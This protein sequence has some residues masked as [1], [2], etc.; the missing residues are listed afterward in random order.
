MTVDPNERNQ[1]SIPLILVPVLLV[2]LFEA[3]GHCKLIHQKL[4]LFAV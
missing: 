3:D 4:A 2:V 1:M